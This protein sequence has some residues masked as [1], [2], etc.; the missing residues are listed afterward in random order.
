MGDKAGEGCAY[1]NLGNNYFALGDLERAL[2]Y[3]E[4][5]L[6]I[7][8]EVG[9]KAREGSAYANIGNA[10][11]SLGDYE[12]AVEYFQLHLTFSREVGDVVGEGSAYANLG[13]AYG[14]LGDSQKALTFYEKQLHIAKEVGDKPSEGHAYA[15][16][17]NAHLNLGQLFES[18][19]CYES[20]VRLFDSIRELLLV[21][22]EWKIS[23][24]DLHNKVYTS[25]WTV[26]LK[27]GKVKEALFT[28]EQGRAQALADLMKLRHCID[29]VS[30]VKDIETWFDTTTTIFMAIG[31]NNVNLWVLGEERVVQFVQVECTKDFLQK[32]SSGDETVRGSK[33]IEEI[34]INGIESH[35]PTYY[36]FLIAPIKKY[37]RGQEIIIV[38]DGKLFWVP[39]AALRDHDNK[40]LGEYLRIRLTP[41]L[42]SLKLIVDR[43]ENY[44]FDSGVLLVGDPWISSD[45][46]GGVLC[47]LPYAKEEVEMIGSILNVTPLTGRLA[48]KC[49]VLK[50]VSSVSLIHIAAHG[51][52]ET[53][54]IALSPNPERPRADVT[55]ED[56]I[57][58]MTDVL[59]ANIR[60]RLVVLSCCHTG[61]GEIK[62]EGVVGI[63]RAFLGAGAASVLVSLWAVDD[64]ATFELMKPF[65]E[66]LVGGKSVNESLSFAQKVLRESKK[67]SDFKYWAPFVVIGNDMTLF[68]GREKHSA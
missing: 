62:A 25:F 66:H 14:V 39:Y 54:E 11:F 12:K 60:A 6:R 43:P 59:Q 31:R 45:V 2:Q 32:V 64:E 30:L 61:R 38:P 18:E 13:N 5:H 29:K 15:N 9:D 19:R 67:F 51:I 50:R 41:S 28:A 47:P 16:L 44:H 57:L 63:A 42:T 24:R 68:K 53:G 17:G 49:E 58:T 4:R 34:T 56:F 10:F 1:G 26:Q 36:K 37:I 33:E 23:W 20:S 35:L 8:K 22:D 27:V 48:T 7:A 3:H 52:I 40:F 65:Y 46:K 55:D 21:K